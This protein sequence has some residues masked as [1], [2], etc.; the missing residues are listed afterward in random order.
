MKDKRENM[1]KKGS[2]LSAF[3]L[4]LGVR[5]FDLRSLARL[6]FRVRTLGLRSLFV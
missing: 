3:I 6:R 4:R 1:R 2:D 5:T